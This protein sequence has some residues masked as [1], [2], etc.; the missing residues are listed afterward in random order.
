MK[1]GD[2]TKM[3]C[4]KALISILLIPGLYSCAKGTDDLHTFIEE[5]KAKQQGSVKP[6]PQF[7]PYRSFEYSAAEM[8]DPFE[9]VVIANVQEASPTS[10]LRPDRGRP[11]EALEGFPLDTLRMVGIL[12]QRGQTWGLVKDPNNVVHWV[13]SGNYAGQNDGKIISITETKISIREI[14]PD[15]LGNYIER[16]ATL[17]LS[18]E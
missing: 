10:S 9:H 11:K 2:F 8:R 13:L 3:K 17:A 5:T 7:R 6:L 16:N 15:G 14:V 4:Y 12:E 18:E 1:R